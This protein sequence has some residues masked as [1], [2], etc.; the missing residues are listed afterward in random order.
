M[1][2]SERDC[3]QISPVYWTESEVSRW[4]QSRGLPLPITNAFEDHLVNGLVAIDLNDEDLLSMGVDNVLHRRRALMELRQ[5]FGWKVW[6]DTVKSIDPDLLTT[7]ASGALR[8]PAPPPVPPAEGAPEPRRAR[9]KSP[10][11]VKLRRARPTT[12]QKVAAHPEA[13]TLSA[14]ARRA[15]AASLVGPLG[16]DFEAAL[17]RALP[18]AIEKLGSPRLRLPACRR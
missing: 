16:A 5:L 11:L 13:P 4:L 2:C 3:Y 15:A 6:D 7:T 8:P 18:V 14:R 1:E 17:L 9:P 12:P 10:Y